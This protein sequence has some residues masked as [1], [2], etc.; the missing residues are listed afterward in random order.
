MPLGRPAGFIM[1]EVYISS[2]SGRLPPESS[3]APKESHEFSLLLQPAP[4]SLPGAG[5]L[6]GAALTAGHGGRWLVIAFQVEPCWVSSSFQKEV[7]FP[8][9]LAA[10][11]PAL[12]RG[13]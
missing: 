12:P 11:L 8:V 10:A 3:L 1:C 9:P 2:T 6:A 13:C 5:P 7:S 4:Q